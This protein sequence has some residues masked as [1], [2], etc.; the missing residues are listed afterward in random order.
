MLS[1]WRGTFIK[2]ILRFVRHDRRRWIA[3]TQRPS[4]FVQLAVCGSI[5]GSDLGILDRRPALFRCAGCFSG[6]AASSVVSVPTA[7]AS[8]LGDF[9]FST[10]AVDVCERSRRSLVLSRY[11]FAF[12]VSVAFF[13]V[14][15]DFSLRMKD[16]PRFSS[17]ERSVFSVATC[18]GLPDSF[19]SQTLSSSSVV[20]T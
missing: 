9:V 10:A 5:R 19:P 2:A 14:F 1:S 20:S 7:S 16:S 6:T 4:L 13:G 18:T 11:D 17:A 3:C 15:R 12:L 8:T